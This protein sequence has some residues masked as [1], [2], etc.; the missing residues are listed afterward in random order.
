MLLASWSFT[1]SACALSISNDFSNG[2]LDLLW[3]QYLSLKDDPADIYEN[4]TRMWSAAPLFAPTAIT[5]PHPA[6]DPSLKFFYYYGN[7]NSK[8]H[9]SNKSD[10]FVSLQEWVDAQTRINRF[11]GCEIITALASNFSKESTATHF[12]DTTFRFGIQILNEDRT[13]WKPNF[14]VLFQEIFPTGKYQN[15]NINKFNIEITGQGSFQ[16]G[17]YCVFSKG[18]TIFKKQD[19]YLETALGGWFPS[20]VNVTGKNYYGGGVNTKGTVYPGNVISIYLSGTLLLKNGW[21]FCLDSNYQQ[22]FQGKFEGKVGANAT[23]NVS[24]QIIFSVA[25]EVQYSF[26]KHFGVLMGAWVTIAGQNQPA[27][28]SIFF[29]FPLIF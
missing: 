3:P 5:V 12:V 6:I 21:S 27:F 20:K 26:T 19:L 17:F 8:W 15:A 29:A 22:N 4:N 23:M 9:V 2:K 11:L 10:G 25:P 28:A 16:S 13:S 24:Q 1:F 14:R 7:Y 18:F